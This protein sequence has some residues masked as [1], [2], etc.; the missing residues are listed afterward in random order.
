MESSSALSAESFQ[1]M[2]LRSS[3]AIVSPSCALLSARSAATRERTSSRAF[4]LA[5]AASVSR[6]KRTCPFWTCSPSLTRM[7][8]MTPP[9]GAFTSLVTPLGSSLPVACTV[10]SIFAKLAQ[11]IP[12]PARPT[13]VQI[14]RRLQLVEGRSAVQCWRERSAVRLLIRVV[15]RFWKLGSPLVFSHR[16]G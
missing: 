16:I 12:N 13:K 2:A 7:S 4:S 6:I 9:S 15:E 3:N 5:F 14:I 10:S 8:R 11:T 1:Q